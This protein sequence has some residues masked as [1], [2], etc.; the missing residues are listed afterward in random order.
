M[1]TLPWYWKSVRVADPAVSTEEAAEAVMPDGAAA[2]F[3]TAFLPLAA[4]LAAPVDVPLGDGEALADVDGVGVDDGA[5]DPDWPAEGVG[6]GLAEADG[7][8]EDDADGVGL[9]AEDE[10]DGEGVGVGDDDGMQMMPRMQV[11]PDCGVDAALATPPVPSIPA[12]RR[13]ASRRPPASGARSRRRRAG[14]RR[15][16]PGRPPPRSWPCPPTPRASA[17]LRARPGDQVETDRRFLAPAPRL[18]GASSS[19]RPSGRRRRPVRRAR[20]RRSRAR[21]EPRRRRAPRR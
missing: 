12:T 8:D 15:P 18:S 9:G 14:R 6:D 4:D 19:A 11:P 21:P 5:A 20:L 7:A 13:P 10:D 16:G 3:L 17:I 1:L 2:S